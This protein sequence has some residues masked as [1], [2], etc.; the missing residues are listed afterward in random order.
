MYLIVAG[1]FKIRHHK[2]D[3]ISRASIIRRVGSWDT[4]FYLDLPE[5]RECR[6]DRE[7]K[8]SVGR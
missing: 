3:S 2:S 7:T 5:K 6:S 1:Y 8:S 4:R